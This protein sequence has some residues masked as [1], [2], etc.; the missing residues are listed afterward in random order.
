MITSM[1]GDP[2][3]DSTRVGSLF[4]QKLRFL[5]SGSERNDHKDLIGS[6]ANHAAFGQDLRRNLPNMHDT[7]MCVHIISSQFTGCVS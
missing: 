7:E 3:C 5:V 2:A 6:H 1:V 4:V